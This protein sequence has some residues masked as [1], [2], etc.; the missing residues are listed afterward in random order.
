LV[1][2]FATRRYWRTRRI[3]SADDGRLDTVLL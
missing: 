3:D 1:V 2:H